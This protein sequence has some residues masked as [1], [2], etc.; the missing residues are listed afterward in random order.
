MTKLADT[1]DGACDAD[2]SLREAVS[3]ANATPGAVLIPAGTYTLSGAAGNNTNASGDLDVTTGMAIYGAGAGQTVIDAAN[4]DRVIHGDPFNGSRASVTLG[5]VTLLDGQVTGDGGGLLAMGLG[6]Y[7]DLD[8]VIIESAIASGNGGGIRMMARGRMVRTVVRGN[9]AGLAG[10]GINAP[11]NSSAIVEIRDSTI[12]SNA[13]LATATAGGGG[14]HSTAVT[15]IV[16]STIHGNTAN[17]H[18]GGLHFLSTGSPA[19]RSATVSGNT[20]DND[21]NGTGAGGGIRFDGS[22]A[23]SV[24]NSVLADNTSAA[25]PDCSNA[26]TATLV[27]AFSHLEATAGACAF[28]GTGD[29]TGSDPGLE[30]LA[31]NGGPTRTRSIV[32][33]SPLVDGGDPTGCADRQGSPLGFDQRGTGFPRS[34]DGNGDGISR[35]DKGAFESETNGAPV[36]A[37]DPLTTAEEVPLPVTFACTDPEGATVTYGG[38]TA[39]HGTVTGTGAARTYTPAQDYTGAESITFTASDGS[40]R[41]LPRRSASRS[42]RSTTRPWPPPTAAVPTPAQLSASPRPACWPTTPTSTT[43]R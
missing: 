27:T 32:A 25:A 40:P 19:L 13:S 3:A 10:G 17:F 24:R 35:C 20:S 9:R 43:T 26:G 22:G 36:C 34:R 8:T 7:T 15:E 12:E 2:C 37:T 30:P 5:D 28:A 33:S 21:G 14:L 18:G 42:R 41:P 29:V 39:Q 1:G 16:N 38:A 31:N 4:V 11:G 23:I 6:N